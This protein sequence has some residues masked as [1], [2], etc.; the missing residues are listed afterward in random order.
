MLSARRSLRV[1]IMVGVALGALS[2]PALAVGD[3]LEDATGQVDDAEQ[4]ANYVI[5]GQ[6]GILG[7][8]IGGMKSSAEKYVALYRDGASRH[9]DSQ[10][11]VRDD[12]RFEARSSSWQVRP[13]TDIAD[14][15]LS[16]SATCNRLTDTRLDG[17]ATQAGKTYS[18]TI[19]LAGTAYPCRPSPGCQDP[20][21]GRVAVFG[22]GDPGS[23]DLAGDPLGPLALTH[24]M[25]DHLWIHGAREDDE[26]TWGAG[27]V[28]IR[29]LD[30]SHG[31]P[32][33]KASEVDGVRV[34]GKLELHRS[35]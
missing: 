23:I 29:S 7:T 22:W 8:L 11:E 32:W 30:G 35:G 34:S 31:Y 26:R 17:D 10:F 20:E 12:C 25:G 18:G 16:G 3:P 15:V 28:R 6:Q 9:I 13:G 21:H 27:E 33:F 4:F 5:E 14:Y 2:L 24:G 19:E 1:S